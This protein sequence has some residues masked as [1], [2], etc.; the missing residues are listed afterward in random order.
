MQE[1]TQTKKII[2]NRLQLILR[3]I[4]RQEQ[5]ERVEREL[6]LLA[7]DTLQLQGD[8]RAL[9]AHGC[10]CFKKISYAL[11]QAAHDRLS[12]EALDLLNEGLVLDEVG[13]KHGANLK[14]ITQR[15]SEIIQRD[16]GK[17]NFAVGRVKVTVKN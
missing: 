14:L 11:D 17:R 4:R 12:D 13:T 9:I 6:A 10:H 8:R 7:L 15:A 1:L 5:L 16:I 3:L 2:K